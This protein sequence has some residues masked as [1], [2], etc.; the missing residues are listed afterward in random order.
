M[1]SGLPVNLSYNVPTGAQ[2]ATAVSPTYRPDY[3]GGDIYS[4]DRSPDN[5]F[6]RAAFATP[7]GTRPFGTFG[8]NVAVGPALYNFDG[9]AH[10]EFGLPWE[11]LKLQ[12]RA[13]FFNLLNRTNFSPPN[14]NFSNTNFGTITSLASP[15]RQIQFALKLVF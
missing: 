7:P 10:K 9:G 6:N 14:A 15:A 11:Q 5:Y 4:T 12:F 3:I 13:E 8:R 1:T 2:V